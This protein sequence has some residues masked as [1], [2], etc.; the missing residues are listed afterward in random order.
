MVAESHL[1]KRELK[2]DREIIARW[3]GKPPSAKRDFL[4]EKKL[5]FSAFC[6][7]KLMDDYKLTDSIKSHAIPCLMFPARDG[8]RVDMMN[9]HKIDEHYCLSDSECST[10]H[11]RKLSNQIIHNMIL[12]FVQAEN[13]NSISQFLVVSDK[14]RDKCLI[15]VDLDAY[16]SVMELVG[17]NDP[18]WRCMKRNPQSPTGWDIRTGDWRDQPDVA[19]RMPNIPNIP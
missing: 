4:I 6:I 12:V 7:R 15:G 18:T 14:E 16:L 9:S 11:I 10:I 1:W 13:D 17:N 3:S 2:N 8:A 19:N 5:V